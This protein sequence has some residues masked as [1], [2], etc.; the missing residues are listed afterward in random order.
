MTILPIA[1]VGVVGAGPA[2]NTCCPFAAVPTAAA[3]RISVSATG[4]VGQVKPLP[5][6]LVWIAVHNARAM[7]LVVSV[8]VAMMLEVISETPPTL[9]P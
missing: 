1:L 6:L 4:A 3:L 2:T 8:A 9:T 7:V 5:A